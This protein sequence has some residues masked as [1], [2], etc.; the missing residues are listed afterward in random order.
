M[1]THQT[2]TVRGRFFSHGTFALLAVMTLG[3][4]FAFTRLL[5]GLEAVTNLTDAYPWGLWIAIDVAC[6]VA[7]AAGGFTTAALIEIF[8]NHKYRPLLRPAVLT[9]WLGYIFV[10][11]GLMFDLGRYWNIWR[12]MFNWQGNSVLFEVGMCVMTYLFVL[13]VEMS[14]SFLDGLR[15]RV[16]EESRGAII[17]RRL[18][19]PLTL[20]RRIV[21]T[22]MPLFVVAGVVLSFMHQSSLGALMVIAPTKMCSLW[23]TPVLP[24]LFLLSAIMVGF[25]M[26]VMESL[27]A[28]RSLGREP[29]MD[30]LSPLAKIIPWFIAAYG[31]VKIL[32]LV[33]RGSAVQ[34]IDT[35]G[36]MVA[37]LVEMILCLVVPFVL[38]LFKPV[39][40]SAGWL[41][42]SS[43]LV[44]GGVVLNR[45]NVFL[46]AYEPPFPGR[47]YFPSVGEIAVTLGLVATIMF[48]Y[49][50]FIFLFPIMPKHETSGPKPLR[51][52]ATYTPLQPKTA[53]TFRG[54]A[55][56]L[57]LLFSVLYAFIHQEAVSGDIRATNWVESVRP[58][59][60]EATGL[61]PAEHAG[62]PEG[63]KRVYILSSRLLDDLDNFYEPTRF[64]HTTHDEWTGGDCAPCH[65]R[66]SMG[67][68]DRIGID[69]HEFHDEMEIHLGGPCASCHDMDSITIQRCDSC[70]WLAN[71]EDDPS[72]LGLKGS[73]HRQC[74]GCH[75]DIPESDAPVDCIGCH[76]PLTPD[77]G[78]LVAVDKGAGVEDVVRECI[79]CHETSA[80]D[81][82]E[83]AHWN[84]SGHSP[85]VGGYEDSASLGINTLVNNYMFGTGPNAEYCA[86]CHIGIGPLE[87][88]IENRD[89]E[90]VDCL[91]C[92][93]TTGTYIKKIGDGGRPVDGVDLAA[94]A[95]SVGRPSR[96]KCGSCHFYS[97]GSANIK[98]GDLEPV[99]AD[100]PDDLDVHMGRYNL[101]CQDCHTTRQHKIAGMSMSAPVVEGRVLCSRCHS[102]T[103]HGIGGEY[104]RHLD[105]HLRSISCQVC[106][107]PR[108]A[109]ESPTRTFIDW[110]Q[111]ESYG[112]VPLTDRGLP[113]WPEQAGVETWVRDLVPEY[114]W[115]DGTRKVKVLG[116]TIDP[117]KTVYLNQPEGDKRN[118]GALISAF[119]THRAMQPYD[120]ENKT[121]VIPKLWGGFWQHFNLEVAIREGMEES[122]MEYSGSYG[123]AAT[124]QYTG[125]H[126][127]IVPAKD[128]LGCQDCHIATA[129]DCRRCHSSI[130]GHEL[131]GLGHAVYP[132]V[133]NR[134]DFEALGY[135]D[136]PAR[137]GGR[138]F[139][140]PGRGTPPS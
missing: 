27:I 42:F 107:I 22:V 21:R 70:H 16:E 31:I 79:R 109:R 10:G 123:F 122:G 35:P 121:L 94:V 136:D 41:L 12:P 39:R 78:D 25:P 129:V 74:I 73:Y 20:L 85:E 66:F 46:V 115:Y 127:E 116:E 45:V 99:L 43:L 26:V 108:I 138:F 96:D 18:E 17:L 80:A 1:S 86:A 120:T 87:G 8:G 64:N 118:P 76:H 67:G 101:L 134:I 128:A 55:I 63:Y 53:W 15:T 37:F 106:H 90:T 102:D 59:E 2:R 61:N 93:D 84:W 112:P 30:L 62:R 7:L 81:I 69:L 4:A 60:E 83:S 28:S 23:Y 14:V 49:R 137:I 36:H 130:R 38:L 52:P 104:S 92:H 111:A 34:F 48:L 9:A 89:P 100:P 77:H 3:G 95:H 44:I 5:T 56:G 72:R 47:G 13:T 98:H 51:S 11:V 33:V 65:H 132:E 75:E 82:L 105:D 58:V 57:L 6:G 126:H 119:K 19:R 29:E 91:I 124:V 97:D 113:D 125:I 71:E 40:E 117:R 68:D 139:I 114:R 140:Q 54:V 131:N 88:R 32:D 133:K 103:P 110:R 135:E 50:V 24:L